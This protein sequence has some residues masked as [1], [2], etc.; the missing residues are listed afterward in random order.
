MLQT[1]PVL[2]ESTMPISTALEATSLTV[3]RSRP[4]GGSEQAICIT[5]ASTSPV[6]FGSTGGVS[7]SFL[8]RNPSTPRSLKSF[9]IAHTD[10]LARPNVLAASSLLIGSSWFRSS[11]SMTFTLLTIIA[12]FFPLDTNFLSLALSSSVRRTSCLT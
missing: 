4:S 7:R 2:M 10:D 5:L 9:F 6:I 11:A 1:E 3:Q 12:G 8:C